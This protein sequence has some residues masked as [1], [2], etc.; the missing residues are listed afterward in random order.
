MIGWAR[1]DSNN[2][3]A[4]WEA[5]LQPA[6]DA[7]PFQSWAWAEYKRSSGWEP[8]RWVAR[9]PDGSTLAC[10][11]VLKKRLPLGLACLGA[12]RS[13]RWISRV[14]VRSRRGPSERLDQYVQTRTILDLCALSDSSS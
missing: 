13:R 6:E 9:A 1:F 10:L 2:D 8:E 4:R 11:Q 14:Q 7:N 5:L 3:P 12:W